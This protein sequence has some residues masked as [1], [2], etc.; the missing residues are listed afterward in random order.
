[1]LRSEQATKRE[2]LNLD[3]RM[4]KQAEKARKDLKKLKTQEFACHEDA[5]KAVEQWRG[6]QPY[7]DV[8]S[9][10]KTIFEYKNSGRPAANQEP[11]HHN[12]QIDGQLFSA[13][14]KRQSAL[15][16]VGLF[17]IATNDLSEKLSMKK[18]LDTYKSQQAVEKGFRFLKSPDFLTSAIY[19][20][21]PERIES[22][23]M[24]MTTCLM[25]Y[26]ALEHQIRH[27]LKAQNKYFPDMKKKPSRNPTAGWVF[28]CFQG[29][30]VLYVD[31]QKPM[32]L[33]LKE[34]HSP[35]IDCLGSVYQQIY[36]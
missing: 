26:A 23:L 24:V 30:A 10:I 27:Q 31:S 8:V 1:L 29:I 19:L 2:S 3:K 4:L 25:V 5:Q 15:Q 20:K 28:Q 16:Q 33:N 7:L 14:E 32:V 36:S 6:K 18:V 9:Q 17:I 34:R 22:L 21:K 11:E 35:I 13:L 12:Y